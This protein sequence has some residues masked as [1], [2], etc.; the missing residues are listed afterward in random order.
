VG[1][2]KS[3]HSPALTA[4]TRVTETTRRS[5]GLPFGPDRGL[6]AESE[7]GKVSPF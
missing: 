4:P 5:T 6:R 1:G 2:V 7:T 3:L